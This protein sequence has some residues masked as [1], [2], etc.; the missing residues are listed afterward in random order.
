MATSA[1][2]KSWI[3]RVV[4]I[5]DSTSTSARTMRNSVRVDWLLLYPESYPFEVYKL[6]S[7]VLKGDTITDA[8]EVKTMA[9]PGETYEFLFPYD[10]RRMY[11]KVNLLDGKVS[12]LV[13]SAH[14]QR[15]GNKMEG[16]F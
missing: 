11:S 5:L 9:E 15:L 10:G 1:I 3:D 12:V 14:E 2:P 16:K 4:N 7:K 13:Y 6:I 8:R